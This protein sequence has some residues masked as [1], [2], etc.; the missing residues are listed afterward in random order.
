MNVPFTKMQ[1]LGND[2][3][4]LDTRLRN[5][6]SH[7]D[8]QK[9]ADPKKGIGCDQIIL[10]EDAAQADVKMRIINA[11]GSEVEACG[12]ATRCVGLFLDQ[13]CS[14][15]E[16]LGGILNVTQKDSVFSVEM[17]TPAFANRALPFEGDASEVSIGNPHLVFFVDHVDA[18]DVETLGPKYEH[19]A[20]FPNRTNAEWAEIISPGH[21]KMRVWER[22]VGITQACGTGACA[23]AAAAIQRGLCD[24]TVT[25]EMP[26][27]SLQI[28]WAGGESPLTM[29]GDANVSFTGQFKA[30]DYV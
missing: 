15:V 23:T 9:L 20:L 8:W 12:N 4:V 5:V 17:G 10:L 16:T 29:I 27:G 7:Y 25:V 14:T 30:D 21:I 22:G 3:V 2:F 11:D 1:A 26:G 28:E 6:L 19:H 13:E 18:V 24:S